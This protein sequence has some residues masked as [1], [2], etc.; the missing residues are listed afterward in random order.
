MRH[1]PFPTRH[2][3]LLAPTLPF[4]AGAALP[5]ALFLVPYLASGSVGA[6]VDDV[7][8][9]PHRRAEFAHQPP[10][11]RPRMVWGLPV[12]LH[13]FLPAGWGRAARRAPLVV[14]ALALAALLVSARQ[15]DSFY[16]SWGMLNAVLPMLAV[17]GAIVAARHDDESLPAQRRF[18]LLATATLCALV[19][20]PFASRIYY[21]YSLPLFALAWLATLAAPLGP[22]RRAPARVGSL[23]LAGFFLGFAVW[24]IHPAFIW[25]MGMGRGFSPDVQKVPLPPP[26]GGINVSPRMYS[27]YTATTD[28]VRE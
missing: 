26:R 22:P 23:L 7:L 14:A 19:Q 1:E 28:F 15:V 25:N 11:P 17:G 21:L 4:L 12:L 13:V 16:V 20:Y 18:L 8:V 3:R 5:V 2:S 24:A 10:P 9:K 6:L 27:R